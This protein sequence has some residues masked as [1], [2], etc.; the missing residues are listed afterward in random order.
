MRHN[1]KQRILD[2]ATVEFSTRGYEAVTMKDIAKRADI[3]PANIYVFY[4]NKEAL[5]QE[6]VKRPMQMIDGI[7]HQNNTRQKSFHSIT[8][9]LIVWS[10]EHRSEALLVANTPMNRKEYANRMAEHI[11]QCEKDRIL[12]K[13]SAQIAADTAI[14]LITDLVEKHA[15]DEKLDVNGTARIVEKAVTDILKLS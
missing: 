15:D 1:S 8:A 3:T 4:E 2:A 10:R 6:A 14:T 7:L 12:S 5:L 9:D 13:D 11:A